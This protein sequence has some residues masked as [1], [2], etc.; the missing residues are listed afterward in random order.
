[1]PAVAIIAYDSPAREWLREIL[2]SDRLT[3]TGVGWDPLDLPA[4][5][6][7]IVVAYP[8]PDPVP[9]LRQT[10]QTFA[11]TSLVVVMPVITRHAVRRV[12][13]AGAAAVVRE[14]DA[15]A[16]LAPAVK[17]VCAGQVCIPHDVAAGL[18]KPVLSSREKQILG[19]VVMGFTNGQIARRLFLAEST[20]K[21]HLSSIFVKLGVASRKEAAALILD[22]DEGLGMGVLA[23]SD[24]GPG[25]P[26]FVV[27]QTKT[28]A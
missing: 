22:P 17:S 20:V 7:A 8:G 10:A 15:G 4:R 6:D 21:S 14:C 24:G 9:L 23:I 13:R 11:Q 19:M 25:G 26:A 1:M 28:A 12:L 27:E 2:E 16:A 18:E 3:V 5:P